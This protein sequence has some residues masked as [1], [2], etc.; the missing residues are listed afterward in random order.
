MLKPK[1]GIEAATRRPWPPA[2]PTELFQP[3]HLFA[4]CLAGLFLASCASKPPIEKVV[5]QTVSVPVSKPCVSAS[6]PHKPATA[7]RDQ[8]LAMTAEDRMKAIAGAWIVLTPWAEE[9]EKQLNLC[10]D[11]SP[12]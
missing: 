1:A 11:Q 9:A 8:I 3:K 6:M 12:H 7:S 10:R 4:V 2:L 5:I